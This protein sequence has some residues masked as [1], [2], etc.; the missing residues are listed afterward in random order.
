MKNNIK[1]RKGFTL[2]EL[3]VVLGVLTVIMAISVPRYLGVQQQAKKDAD[4]ALLGQIAKITELYY[5]QGKM[6]SNN[7]GT[8][9]S[10]SGT[11]LSTKLQEAL[12]ND[13]PNLEFQSTSSTLS[14]V[15]LYIDDKGI[16]KVEFGVLKYPKE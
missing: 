16:A 1:N 2:I 12:K 3:I 13:I 4:T 10:A 14:E 6:I 7:Y 11:A 8:Y 9:S 5:I 15:T